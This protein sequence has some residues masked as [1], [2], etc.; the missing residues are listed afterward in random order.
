MGSISEAEPTDLVAGL[1][2]GVGY[3]R[4][5]GQEGGK[6]IHVTVLIR[7]TLEERWGHLLKRDNRRKKTPNKI[8]LQIRDA[9]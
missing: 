4:E 1:K 5:W 2:V 8:D 9:C 6:G 7:R 3:S